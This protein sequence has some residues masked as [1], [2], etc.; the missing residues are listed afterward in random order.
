M[1][2]RHKP[3]LPQA[4][5]GLTRRRFIQTSTTALA[6]AT[7]CAPLALAG[8]QSADA[9]L[10]AGMSL[11]WDGTSVV[12]V[13]TKR[14]RVCLDGIWRFTPAAS[15]ETYPP[16]MG[17][18]YINVPGSWGNRRHKGKS[19][20][21]EVKS[22]DFVALGSGPQW[23]N[24][25]G[26]KVTSAWYER[27]API[28]AEWQD[29]V[30]RLCFD[31]MCTDGIV[32]VNGEECGQ[33]PWPWGSVDITHAIMPGKTADIRVLVAA[34]AESEMVGHFWQNAFMAVTY[35]AAKLA[36]RGLTG[37]VYLENR[38]SD[39]CVGDL[40]IHTSTRKN[41]V[42]LDVELSGI[43]QAGQVHFVADMLNEKGAVEKSFTADAAVEAK[44]TQTVTVSW[45]WTN[46]RQWDVDQPDLYTL[47]LTVTGA[48]VDD[49]YNQEFGFREFW[50]DG[51]QFYLNG[52]VIHLRQ[53]CFYDGPLGQV[54]D[55]FSEVGSWTPDTR[56]DDS[57]A[58][59]ELDRA[60]H[61]GY[62][63]AVYMLDANRYMRDPSG[64]LIWKENQKRALDRAFVWMRHYRN[65]PSLVMW[66]A[67]ANF[68]NN[69]IDLDPR[70][71]G[72]HGWALSDQRWQQL[73]TNAKEM[74]TK[75]KKLDPTRVYYSHEGA[76]TGDVH[77]ANCYLDLLP[78]Q[79]REEWLSAWAE[80][81]E[82]PIAMTEFGTPVECTFL[83]GRDG[84]GSNITSEPLLTEYAAIYFG[85]GAYTSEGSE[86][87]QHLISQFRGGM[88]YNSFQDHL[89]PFPDSRKIQALFRTRTWRSWRTAGLSG[90]LRTWSWIQ[91]ELQEVNFPTLAWIAG[92]P[93]TYTAKDHHFSA[94][95]KF[96]KQII[97]INDMRQPQEFRATWI[98]AVGGKTVGKGELRGSLAVSEVR[99]IPI[100][101]AAPEVEKDGKAD[102]QI[103]LTATIGK[104]THHDTFSFRVF[105]AHRLAEGQIA[106]VDPDGLT[107][108]MLTNLGYTAQA[109]NGSA[110]FVVIGRNGLR[111]D[112]AMAASLEPHLRAGGRALIFAQDPTWMT[113]AL[114]WR[115]CPKVSRRV[116]PI[117]NSPVA[118][119]IDA[120]DL[121]D[122]TGSSTLIAAYPE[123]AGDYHRGNEGDQ[124]YAGWHWGNRGGVT[125]AAIEKPHRSGWTPLLECEFDLAYP[126][127]MELDYG[128]G[129]LIVCTLDLE[130]HAALD[131]AARLMAER[132]MD[133]AQHA[134]LAP[135][136]SKVVYAGGTAGAAWLDRIGVDYQ[137]SDT[138]DADTEL[139]LVGPDA[140]VDTA[141]LNA[142][143][144]EG[145]RAFF[146]PRAQTNGWL[147]TTLKSTAADFAGSLSVPDWPQAKGLS[148][149]DLRW[150]TYLDSPAWILNDGAEIAADGLLGR[151]T[152]GKGVAIFCQVDPD[153]FH[154]DEK[155]Y[156]RYTRWRSTR[157][158][159]QLLANLGASFPVD[160]RIFHPLDTW[161][162]NLDGAW[163]MK[164]T[165]KLAPAASDA[166]AY[167]DRGVT[168][169]AQALVGEVVPS[170]GWTPVTLPRM[171][172]FFTEYDGEAVFRKEIVVPKE[173]VG[174]NMILALGAL[175]D[176]DNTYFNGIEV[177]HTDIKASKW[178]EALR[179]YV[180][181]GRL[182]KSGRNV[183][184][185]R[186]F[187][188]CGSGG[189]A[190]KT[191]LPAAPNGDRS[192]HDSTGPRVG[193]EMSL[194]RQPEHVQTLSWYCADYRTDFPMGDNPYRY[195]RF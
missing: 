28:P 15:G 154:A 14:S 99:K 38:S 119:G 124:P 186:L 16:K 31:R 109:W 87:R 24:Y 190:G 150:R 9:V 126:P 144:E 96:Q 188:R 139:V 173:E 57:D 60:D 194:S 94:G 133:Y 151:K 73:L 175:A 35:S 26:T 17:W 54:G 75:V 67:G 143:L 123:Y 105:G 101:I 34:I 4:S 177:G 113:E 82:M 162:L 45:P 81:G 163:Q 191:G 52:S 30:I 157:A 97:L 19:S 179:N 23:D 140:T 155:T 108:K 71:F 37:S 32:Y 111:D 159:A 170:N 193:L 116:F 5:N 195:Y 112:L 7:L 131:P 8:S 152:V 42:A 51:R 121:R 145:G 146:L 1:P 88:L 65:H 63:T 77:S 164:V 69:A 43:A 66:I 89:D 192:G 103:M 147:G 180:I 90:G 83:R 129:R 92:Q 174:K 59:L 50:I 178:R 25:D 11:N 61:K 181:P 110:S 130:D 74:F 187:N 41:D 62:L 76:D 171:V 185:V 117:P 161:S 44:P 176:F 106:I 12:T 115:V 137:R 13:T 100:E 79:E 125:S 104:A 36:T 78:L 107:T 29:S 158:V 148:A 22:S 58:G 142:Y 46:P 136:V 184:A 172:P 27:Q 47:R 6:G 56:G 91:D 85:T 33:V 39:A 20:D 86:Y 160:S 166:K 68:F 118:Q 102:G 64:N 40:F 55:N 132:V 114:G 80:N 189:F 49:Q 53:P 156:F 134:P 122:W 141:A 183:L 72:R 182:V 21:N 2:R 70:H 18:A 95:Q 3:K 168:P 93:E 153:R 138:L 120:D 167:V 48:G 84:F 128:N 135:R 98:A 10:P 169:A 127:L 165:L 149:S